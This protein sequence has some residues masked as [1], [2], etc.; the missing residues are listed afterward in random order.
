VG[1]I[2]IF[3]IR[4]EIEE[5]VSQFL[6]LDNIY[7]LEGDPFVKYLREKNVKD[8]LDHQLQSIAQ[9][10]LENLPA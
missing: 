5:K 3:E 2:T 8:L 4:I 10:A 1:N 7:R 6:S 9:A